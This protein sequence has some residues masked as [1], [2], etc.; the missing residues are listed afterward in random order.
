MARWNYITA[1]SI[2]RGAIKLIEPDGSIGFYMQRGINS[3]TQ[4]Q[5]RSAIQK[6][7]I[8][9]RILTLKELPKNYSIS[10]EDEEIMGKAE[11]T[12]KA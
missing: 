3:M 7:L 10:F 4:E 12:F 2:D 6:G 1:I 11:A 5:L 9:G 8:D